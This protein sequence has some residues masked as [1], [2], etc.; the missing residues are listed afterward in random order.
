MWVIAG[1]ERAAVDRASRRRRS[2]RSGLYTVVMEPLDGDRPLEPVVVPLEDFAMAAAAEESHD[3][4]APILSGV[5]IRILAQRRRRSPSPDRPSSASRQRRVA[6]PAPGSAGRQGNQRPRRPSASAAITSR[7]SSAARWSWPRRRSASARSNRPGRGPD[8]E[9]ALPGATQWPSASAQRPREESP[10][11]HAPRD[12][13]D[14]QERLIHEIGDASRRFSARLH[15]AS[16]SSWRVPVSPGTGH[17][18]PGSG[19]T[20]AEACR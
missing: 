19:I 15:A 20:P 4:V 8:R 5:T 9:R 3:S 13:R 7:Y 2:R 12:P 16:A 17:R 6:S 18:A 1:W 10:R 11:S 14:G